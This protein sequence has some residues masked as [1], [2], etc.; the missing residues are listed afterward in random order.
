MFKVICLYS[1]KTK[2]VPRRLLRRTE[3]K[4]KLRLIEINSA[5]ILPEIRTGHLAITNRSDLKFNLP[6]ELQI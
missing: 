1:F 6:A 5:G 2:L 3:E 4:K